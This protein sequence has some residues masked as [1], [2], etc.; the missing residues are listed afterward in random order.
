[1]L[2]KA[3]L[4]RLYPDAWAH[5]CLLLDNSD[6]L[7]LM[8]LGNQELSNVVAAGV[9]KFSLVWQTPKYLDLER[10]SRCISRVSYTSLSLRSHH[11]GQLV[12]KPLSTDLWRPSLVELELN[13][14]GSIGH[15]LANPL[16]LD[17]RLPLLISLTLVDLHQ[18]LRK[19]AP[20]I[21]LNRLPSSLSKLH[22]TSEN[23]YA[24]CS[25][26]L[27]KLPSTLK[28]L[29]LEFVPTWSPLASS[30]DPT[31]SPTLPTRKNTNMDLPAEALPHSLTTLALKGHRM[32]SWNVKQLP[33]Q[34]VELHIFGGISQP[35]MPG[36]HLPLTELIASLEQLHTLTLT[37][38]LDQYDL[39]LIPPSVTSLSCRLDEDL[40]INDVPLH[41]IHASRHILT[42][43]SIAFTMIQPSTLTSLTYFSIPPPGHVWYPNTL[44]QLNAPSLHY[45]TLPES[46]T[47]LTCSR[48]SQFRNAAPHAHPWLLPPRLRT[49]EL[50]SHTWTGRQLRK[51]IRALPASIE[52]FTTPLI[53]AWLHFLTFRSRK[54]LLPALTH[55]SC[56]SSLPPRI[57]T[58]LPPTLTTFESA[59]LVSGQSLKFLSKKLSLEIFKM[60]NLRR[61]ALNFDCSARRALKAFPILF[62][63]LPRKVEHLSLFGIPWLSFDIRWPVKLETLIYRTDNNLKP[64][65]RGYDIGLPMS[66]RDETFST[67]EELFKLPPHLS[68]VT[69]DKKP[70]EAYFAAQALRRSDWYG[71]QL[72]GILTRAFEANP[73]K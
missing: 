23:S 29:W 12:W 52:S 64:M 48:V 43:G 35:P 30:F 32:Q 14:L 68:Y 11:A 55:L 51:I 15:I 71:D 66:L 20:I 26:D 59:I 33:P 56:T 19:V 65:L 72:E 67:T 16:P 58:M 5:I 60:S 63:N 22:L 47:S 62:D 53:L 8:G 4:L 69:I 50:E 39:N 38:T 6:V 13:F 40:D 9:R 49:L 17:T 34:L 31:A 37:E 2:E 21:T 73:F 18:T 45:G 44:T 54:G 61:L 24:F 27:E 46:L 42:T 7:R 36:H 57:L 10:V 28:T 70:F 3:P 1:M 41:V 25:S